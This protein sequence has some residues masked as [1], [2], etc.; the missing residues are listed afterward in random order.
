MA[1]ESTFNFFVGG[2]ALLSTVFSMLVYLNSYLPAPRMKLFD[3]LLVETKSIYEKASA[4][5]LL[6]PDMSIEAQDRL[7]QYETQ[8]DD[9]RAI[10]YGV[11]FPIEILLSFFG[12][13]SSKIA[14]L[15]S[16]L[17][18][19][20]GKLLTTSQKERARRR[21][22]LLAR[23]EHRSITVSRSVV[24]DTQSDSDGPSQDPMGHR[25]DNPSAAQTPPTG[26]CST[27]PRHPTT[28]LWFFARWLPDL[29]SLTGQ[30]S[31][32][33]QHQDEADRQSSVISIEA[34]SRSSTVVEV[35]PPENSSICQPRPSL[36]RWIR[37][38]DNPGAGE[39]LEARSGTPTL[40]THGAWVGY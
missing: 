16:D 11:L 33:V 38:W 34:S 15:S 39:D 21:V 28:S 30:N 20:R 27:P 5:G 8:G 32:S 25:Y 29:L 35:A 18:E 9:L 12:G 10:T 40:S 17:K 19:L 7:L 1:A 24:I 14:S 6:P 3:E 2:L 36:I 37:F 26:T 13:H 22:E 31:P 4:E 23:E